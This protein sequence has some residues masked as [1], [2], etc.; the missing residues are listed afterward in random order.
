MGVEES[1]D[2]G[3][4]HEAAAAG[5]QSRILVV[6]D[7][8][9]VRSLLQR[10][11]EQEGFA[12]LLAADGAGLRQQMAAAPDLILLDVTLPGED[13]LALM[14]EIRAD[15]EVPIILVSGKGKLLDKVLGLEMGADDYIAKPFNLR[16]LLARVRSALRRG[17]AGAPAAGPAP[18]ATASPEAVLVF[19]GWRLNLDRRDL[20][21][22]D[23]SP[24]A[25]T[26][27]EFDLMKAF[28]DSAN[29]VLTRDQ[30][31][32]LAKGREW[33]AFD[34]AIDTQVA[35][36]RKKIEP[37]PANP[38]LIKSVRGVGYVFTAAVRRG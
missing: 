24:V 38:T 27:S 17:K 11:L 23:G 6:D 34:R 16:E 29:R 32:T 28:V 25:L 4:R 21:A 12:V 36:L 5:G 22:P 15:S 19:D 31:M 10:Y 35:R 3:A 9:R 37:D 2:S 7:D 13:G 8:P 30:L 33:E 26:T 20:R 18:A 14:R 1:G